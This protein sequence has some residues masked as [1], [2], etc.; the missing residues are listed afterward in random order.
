MNKLRA[1]KAVLGFLCDHPQRDAILGVG[2]G[3]A[4]L[5][6]QLSTLRIRQKTA[7]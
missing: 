1:N 4:I 6:E 7:V 2:A 3:I 5:H